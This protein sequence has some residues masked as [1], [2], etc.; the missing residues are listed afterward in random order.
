MVSHRCCQRNDSDFLCQR[1]PSISTNYLGIG[2]VNQVGSTTAIGVDTPGGAEHFDGY[3][4]EINFID[5]QAIGSE[6]FGEYHPMTGQW[7]PK[8]YT[9]TC[10]TNGFYLSFNDGTNTTEL[11]RDRSGN[12]NHWTPNNISLT[13]GPS[14]DWMDDTPANNFSVLNPVLPSSLLNS[15]SISQGNLYVVY[16]LSA[17]F[18]LVTALFPLGLY[19]PTTKPS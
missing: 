17:V 11:C 12:G 2:Q 15:G 16:A 18:H 1:R 10:G 7:V 13:V 8:K 19:L 9:G 4:S 3:L 14:N 5:C 6:Q